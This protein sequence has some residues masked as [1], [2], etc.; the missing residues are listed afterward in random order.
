MVKKFF[1]PFICAVCAMMSLICGASPILYNVAAAEETQGET[2]VDGSESEGETLPVETE[3]LA[4]SETQTEAETQGETQS[5]AQSETQEE[6]NA[7]SEQQTESESETEK[8]N[9]KKIF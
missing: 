8:K 7:E 6:T 3:Q 5:E 2:V 9:G 4:E 1:R